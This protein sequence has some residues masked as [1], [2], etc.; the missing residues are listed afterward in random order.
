MADWPQIWL[1]RAGRAAADGYNVP[2]ARVVPCSAAL[3]GCETDWI[4][5]LRPLTNG[6]AVPFSLGAIGAS[7]WA[8]FSV[9]P[10]GATGFQLRA[11]NIPEGSIILE[12]LLVDREEFDVVASVDAQEGIIV[13]R[14]RPGTY[15]V[16]LYDNRER[17][18]AV[19][20]GLFA[21]W[22]ANAPTPPGGK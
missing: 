8:T 12:L 13:A 20:Y 4:A 18:T 17:P 14:L 16:R 22:N 6:V 10:G 3:F 2:N 1:A 9:G 7:H 5:G 19:D 21:T 15:Y 11:D